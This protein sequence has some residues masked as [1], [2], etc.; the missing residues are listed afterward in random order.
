[1]ADIELSAF[2]IVQEAVTNVVRHAG[3]GHCRVSVGYGD[4]ELSVDVVDEGR[5]VTGPVPGRGFG[6]VGM[7]ERVGLLHGRFEA[8]PRPGGGFRVAAV[9]PLPAPAPAVVGARPGPDVAD[10]AEVR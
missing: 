8:G 9:L 1:M 10:A 7:R 5:G 3:T 4:E 2:R 6:L